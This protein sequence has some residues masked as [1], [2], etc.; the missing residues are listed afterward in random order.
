MEEPERA[1]KG[2]PKRSR[3]DRDEME[4][5]SDVFRS[6]N[7]GRYATPVSMSTGSPSSPAAIVARRTRGLLSR[8]SGV[9][10]IFWSSGA[11]AVVTALL[12]GH[13]SRRSVITLAIVA[14][15]CVLAAGIRVVT[16]RRLASWTLHVDVGAATACVSLLAVVGVAGHVPFADLY[17][18]VVLFAALYFRPLGALVHVAVAGTA[19]ALVLAFG[20]GTAAPV[21]AW[22]GV[23]GTAGVAGAIVLGLVSVLRSA[24]ADDPLTGCANRR[25][26]DERLEEELERS[27]RTGQ[28]L[29]IAMIDLDAFKTVNDRGGHSAGDLLLQDV[30]QRWRG[31]VRDGGDFLARLGG[32][33]F[34]ILAPGSDETGIRRLGKRL[35]EALPA[36]VSASIGVA[37]WDRTE[38]AGAL[39]R[40]ADQAMYK[41]KQRRPYEGFHSA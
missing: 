29:S 13:W 33:E 16:S 17:V 26:W 30:A 8:P 18:W 9:A 15:T 24:A 41:T 23:F 32:D 6:G 20:P 10:A 36:G 21:Q 31:T 5:V 27:R 34:A 37:T 3:L 39:L 40:R 14:G 19:Y 22:F 28:P 11:V 7:R 1:P 38:S 2:L 4:V 35:V 12:A 25:Y